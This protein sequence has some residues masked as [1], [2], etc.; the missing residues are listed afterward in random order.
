MKTC[1][2][3]S[4]S[5]E[6]TEF[7]DVKR[8]GIVFKTAECKA[9]KK[10]YH[11]AYQSKNKEKMREKQNKWFQNNKELQYERVKQFKKLNPDKVKLRLQKPL[12]KIANRIRTRLWHAVKGGTVSGSAVRDL[13]CTIEELKV[14][15]ESQF[16]PGMSWDNWTTDGW[17]IDHIVPLCSF[18]L[19]DPEQLKKACHYTNLQPMWAEDNLKKGRRYPAV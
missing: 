1:S 3:C 4:Q 19:T 10:E 9:C 17:H 15:L 16:Q 12:V 2:I 18:D 5:K 11:K 14:H 7:Y 13:G 6:E 8:R